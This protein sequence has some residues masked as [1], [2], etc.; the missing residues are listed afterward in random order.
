VWESCVLKASAGFGGGVDG[1]G[2]LA[3][4]GAVEDQLDEGS[5]TLDVV[6]EDMF[7][8]CCSLNRCSS[9]FAAIAC[10]MST[11]LLIPSLGSPRNESR[12]EVM[13]DIMLAT[14]M[15]CVVQ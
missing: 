12:L 6:V 10:T 8:W 13:T 4:D 15:C 1:L 14:S 3:S 7:E 5:T 9:L 2:E 11:V